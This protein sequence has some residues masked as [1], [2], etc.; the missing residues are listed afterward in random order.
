MSTTSIKSRIAN[1]TT[2]L[3]QVRPSILVLVIGIVTDAV[4]TVHGI[5]IMGLVYEAGPLAS[6]IIPWLW[7]SGQFGLSL[8]EAA[9]L[10]A[11]GYVAAGFAVA[12]VLD[13]LETDREFQSHSASN[14]LFEW[15]T[16]SMAAVFVVSPV[17]NIF[18][19]A[20]WIN[21]VPNAGWGL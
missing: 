8:G 7:R 14:C 19:L 13:Y 20:N 2:R 4:T 16:R 6:K 11:Y 9:G 21:H 17:A 1:P 5:S 3:R 12:G 15:S 10:Y 18:V